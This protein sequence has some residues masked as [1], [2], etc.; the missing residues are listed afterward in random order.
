MNAL[1][2]LANWVATSNRQHTPANLERA[3]HSFIDTLACHL[4]GRNEPVVSA[5]YRLM[6]AGSCGEISAF[7]FGRTSA[8]TAA[9]VNATAA[10]AQDFDDYNRSSVAHTS[11]VLIPV[12]LAVA[13]QY[14]RSGAQCLDASIVGLEAMVYL[15]SVINMDHYLRGW[16]ATSTL[17]SIGAA[18]AASR[19]MQLDAAQT[20]A[21][22]SLATSMIGGFKTQFGTM[23]KPLHAGLAAQAGIN[24]AL[25]A[26]GGITASNQVFDGN[27]GITTL[28][29]HSDASKFAPTVI[30][31]DGRLAIER[32]GLFVKCY[33]CC[34]YS[35]RSIDAMISLISTNQIKPEQIDKI[36][37]EVPNRHAKVVSYLNPQDV[38][39]AR[40]SFP[41]CLAIAAIHGSVKTEHFSDSVIRNPEVQGLL[42]RVEV[43]PY[44]TDPKLEDLSPEAPDHI[45]V[46][47]KD[48]RIVAQ[49]VACS[50]GSPEQPLNR[51][52]LFEKFWECAGRQTKVGQHEKIE[53]SF[54]GFADCDSVSELTRQFD[55]LGC[56][57]KSRA[58]PSPARSM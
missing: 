6:A 41:F 17:G 56:R 3:I 28:W 9:L 21:A 49:S 2:R 34:G 46:T 51:S 43:H 27:P 55:Q 47:L 22:M 13:E 52:E 15:G 20:G 30:P 1:E 54:N 4:S 11:A 39:Q 31:H 12:S 35:S 57:I 16:H 45:R 10:H 25:F 44:E 42:Q 5:V 29:S 19:L 38:L 53:A 7:G 33:P 8:A 36:E 26:A 18:A 50:R 14:E 32:E 24:A 23:A 48:G 37:I 58:R 40:F